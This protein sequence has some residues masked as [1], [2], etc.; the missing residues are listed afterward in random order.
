MSD[1]LSADALLSQ[2]IGSNKIYGTLVGNETVNGIPTRRY[3]LDA[4]AI[5]TL[6]KRK[7]ATVEL[8]SGDMWIA[9]QGGYIVRLAVDGAGKLAA[10]AGVDFSGN[11][12]ITVD[13]SN[14][15]RVPAIRLPGQCNNPMRLP[16]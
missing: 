2:L 4:R 3:R 11:V 15:N 14:L 5:N 10:A 7:G 12:S 16:G 8:K 1:G 13:V 9:T 6:A